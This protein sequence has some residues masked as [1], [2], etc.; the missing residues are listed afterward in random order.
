MA[1]RAG[2]D[3]RGLADRAADV[4]L[5]RLATVVGG[6]ARAQVIVI[7][8]CVL[9]LDS[10][11]KGMVGALA[12]ALRQDLG[13]NETEVGALVAVSS[14]AGALAALPVGLLTD[15]V[16]RVRLLLVSIALWAAAMAAGG[17]S[18]S[19][20]MLLCSR[21]ALGAVSATSGPTIS[22][23]VG[24]YF[25]VAERGR[26]YGFILAG[27]MV[28]AGFGLMVIG[29]LGYLLTWR[30]SFC[31]LALIGL[32]LFWTVK[33]GLAEPARGGQ[34][35]MEPE[36]WRHRSRR[37]KG[38]RRDD[39]A[40][41]V[42]KRRAIA[43]DPALVLHRDP[44]RM[45]LWHA[46]VYT[47][48]IPTN[49]LLIV[50]SALGYFFFA[51]LRTFTVEFVS[52]HYGLGKV[53]VS[54]LIP[55]VGLGAL[56]GVLCGGRLAD[57]LMRRRR[58]D[59]RVVVPGWACVV[60]VAVFLPAII[61]T[62]LA[63]AIPLYTAGAFA[64]AAANPP[65]DAARL[66]VM[67]FRLWGRAESTRTF[68]RMGA[69]AGSPLVFGFAVDMLSDPA[70]PASGLE[71]AFLIMLAPLAANGVILW[72]ARHTYARDVATAAASEE[73]TR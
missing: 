41:E 61:T 45:P 8:A 13:I 59:A 57:R 73:S 62:S 40:R 50:A 15:R 39:L 58:T 51:G 16:N 14:G 9:A 67:H 65:L 56:A 42:V 49:R 46:V 5:R 69:E 28:G 66:D 52:G 70:S 7:L 18:G 36:G 30:L 71:Y 38:A 43:P 35:R 21:V 3:D 54:L 6:R 37:R 31:F 10:A 72:R 55:I 24:D 48:L 23:L 25:P 53:E 32:A 44:A 34:S 47:L 29:D 1:R 11:D 63:A 12:P 19:F 60:A 4:L 22:S 20:E 33:C 26:I 27:E 2:R 64:L 17:L 68:L